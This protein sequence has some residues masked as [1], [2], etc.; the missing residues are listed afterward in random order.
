M[1][2]HPPD[3][4][5]RRF[6]RS[7]GE[8]MHPVRAH[9]SGCPRCS[10]RL[11]ALRARRC[12]SAYDKALAASVGLLPSLQSAYASERRQ[13][14]SLVTELLRHPLKRQRILI[15]NH[16]RFHTWGIYERLIELSGK[17]FP[18]NPLLGKELAELALELADLLDTELYGL[19]AVEDLRGRA[20]AYIGNARRIF[21]DLQGAEIALDLALVHLR[22]GTRD[23][24]E[25]AVWL[26][27]KASLLRAQRRFDEAMRHLKRALTLFWAVGDRHRAGRT[28]VSMDNVLHHAG[29]PEKG[30]P[31][32]MRAL[33]LIDEEQEPWLLVL[34][35]H[36]LIDDL[37]ELGRFLD[38]QRLIQ[39]TQG[40]VGHASDARMRCRRRWIE[41]KIA[42]GLG[43]PEAAEKLLLDARERYVEIGSSYD[44]AL[45]SLELAGLYAEQSRTAEQKVLA[46]EMIPL[47]SSLQIRRETLAAFALWR[48][49]VAAERAGAELAAQVAASLKRS[50]MD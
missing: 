35:F 39:E 8:K 1:K 22:R 25:R 10:R 16:R 44:V 50:R 5:L 47:F 30:V 43:Q 9:L 29:Q 7:S 6:L 34:A 33:G 49:A 14:T 27:L 32:L 19:E 23:S 4:L 26:D 21:C 18:H 20:W 2:S 38:A 15:Q 37:A 13:A 42:R 46:K 3:L 40:L 12:A 31:L 24:W 48:K 36:N 17:A 11:R 28:L 41:A 45:I